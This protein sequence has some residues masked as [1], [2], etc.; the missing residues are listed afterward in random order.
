MTKRLKELLD[1]RKAS[2]RETLSEDFSYNIIQYDHLCLC[3]LTVYPKIYAGGANGPGTQVTP[4]KLYQTKALFFQ[5]LTRFSKFG[6]C[7]VSL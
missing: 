7:P 2:S 3:L 6:D 4:T 1:N 5:L